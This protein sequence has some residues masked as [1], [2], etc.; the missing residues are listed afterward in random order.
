MVLAA[1]RCSEAPAPCEVL[2]SIASLQA[3]ST[4]LIALHIAQPLCRAM[5][6]LILR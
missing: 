3:H 2:V 5:W 6:H 4:Y 1:C